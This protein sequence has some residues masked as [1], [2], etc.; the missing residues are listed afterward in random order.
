MWPHLV[1]LTKAELL[2]SSA[3]AISREN[4]QDHLSADWVANCTQLCLFNVLVLVKHH[5]IRTTLTP[6][7]LYI[8]WG[9]KYIKM[10]ILP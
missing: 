9:M 5:K 10:N 8:D 1:Q 7:G 6:A 3:K 4:N 2:Y